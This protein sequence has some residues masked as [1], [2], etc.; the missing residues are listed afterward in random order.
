MIYSFSLLLSL[1]SDISLKP[2]ARKLK[3]SKNLTGK[4]IDAGW[5][6]LYYLVATIWGFFIFRDVCIMSE[7]RREKNKRNEW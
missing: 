7:K 2:L 4:F 1:F 5:F 6:S 3:L